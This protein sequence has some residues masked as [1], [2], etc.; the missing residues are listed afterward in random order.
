ML[1]KLAV[2]LFG[3][4][5]ES[6]SWATLVSADS[7]FDYGFYL[8]LRQE[9]MGDVVDLNSGTG[10][11]D[12]FF[13]AKASL[14]GKLDFNKEKNVS[15]FIKLTSEPKYYIDHG[16]LDGYVRDEI[17][18]D[19][20]YLDIKD[21]FGS[22][23]SLRIGRQDFLGTFGEGLLIMDGNPLDGSRSFYFNAIKATWKINEKNSLDF[24]YINNPHDDEFLPVVDKI[25]PEQS[26]TSSDEEGFV[27][28]SRNKVNDYF[29]LEP[30]YIYKTE[31][32]IGV[33]PELAVNT[34][35]LRA[36][37]GRNDWKLRGEFAHQFGEYEGGRNREANGG[38]LFLS[39]KFKDAPLSPEINAGY[40]YLSGDD[41]VSAAHEGWNPLFSRFPFLSELYIFT[42]ITEPNAGVAYWTNLQAY[43]AGVKVNFNPKANL[44]LCYNYLLANEQVATGGIF[45]GDGKE[46]G[47]LYQATLGYAFNKNIDGLLLAEYFLPGDFYDKTADEA[48]FLR[49]QLQFKF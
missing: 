35:G 26:L 27:L 22:P 3:V 7:N 48:V 49:W 45:S 8:R 20:L 5:L 29:S 44:S 32:P 21:I 28:Y 31:A 15:L 13:R 9:Y 17:F 16:T 42:Y 46:R 43:R 34:V 23:L 47:H 6:T 37:Y 25:P 2:L 11:N 4:L 14:W 18:F 36:V 19:N 41:A 33:V 24:V 39:R 12:N 38:Y 30:Y 40:V 1:R 10:V